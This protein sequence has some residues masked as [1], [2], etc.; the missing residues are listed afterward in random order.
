MPSTRHWLWLCILCRCTESTT[1][2]ARGNLCRY[3]VLP[4]EKARPQ[5]LIREKPGHASIAARPASP[6]APPP[7]VAAAKE[8]Q[9]NQYDDEESSVVHACTSLCASV[10]D[11]SSPARCQLNSSHFPQA[12]GDLRRPA[13]NRL[14]QTS[15]Q[16]ALA[17]S[18]SFKALATRRWSSE[19]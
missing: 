16:Q 7:V 11:K 10:E 9:D 1:S 14:G 4:M 3:R 18:S 15:V 13:P 19:R 12:V 2:S 8:Y 17:R 5:G 6:P